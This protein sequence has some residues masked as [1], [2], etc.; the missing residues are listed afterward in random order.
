M[1]LL[2]DNGAALFWLYI[3]LMGIFNHNDWTIGIWEEA[4]RWRHHITFA[5]TDLKS[6][7]GLH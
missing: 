7:M 5:C 3:G 1:I 4:W 6:K 2:E